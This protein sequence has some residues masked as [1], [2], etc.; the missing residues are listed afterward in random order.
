MICAESVLSVHGQL[1]TLDNKLVSDLCL[2]F[3]LQCKVMKSSC[4]QS[5]LLP[6]QAIHDGLFVPSV[7]RKLVCWE[8]FLKEVGLVLVEGIKQKKK[9]RT[10]K[11]AAGKLSH[12][13]SA[14]ICCSIAWLIQ[15]SVTHRKPLLWKKISKKMVVLCS[16]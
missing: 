2:R 11:L 4:S 8:A 3:G 13:T 12:V 10:F 7:H 15:Q 9:T 1:H 6:I 5:L 16:A 14:D